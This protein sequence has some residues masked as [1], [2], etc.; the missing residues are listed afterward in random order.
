MAADRKGELVESFSFSEALERLKAGQR[1]SRRGWNGPGQWLHLQRP[2]AN[3]KMTLPYIYI[4]TVQGDLVPWLASQTDMLSEDWSVVEVSEAPTAVPV[5]SPSVPDDVKAVVE[6]AAAQSVDP[7]VLTPLPVAGYTDQSVGAVALVNR[8][9]EAEERV[10][11]LLDLLGSRDEVDKR[12][13]AIGR[14]HLEQA[15]MAINRSVFKP[16][17]VKLPEDAEPAPAPAA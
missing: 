7:P 14:T 12:W 5:E 15:F 1:V 6:M 10:L 13:L 2:D 16:V 3:S 9:K 4:R 8:N 17:R 11:R